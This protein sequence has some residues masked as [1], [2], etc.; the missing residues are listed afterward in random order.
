ML[1]QHAPAFSYNIALAGSRAY[2]SIKKG[3]MDDSEYRVKNTDLS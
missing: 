1:V 2:Y 3:L